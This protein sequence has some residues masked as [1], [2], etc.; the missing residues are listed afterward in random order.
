MMGGEI[1]VESEFG[2]GTTFRVHLPV[3]VMQD[4][5]SQA[6]S[7]PGSTAIAASK[8]PDFKD[9]GVRPAFI[10]NRGC[11]LVIDDDPVAQHLVQSVLVK[12]GYRVLTAGGGE[13]G[14][15]QAREVRPDAITLDVAMPGIDGWNVLSALKAA[16][17]TANI[18]VIIVSMMENKNMGFALGASEYLTKPVN[19]DRLLAIVAKLIRPR[20]SHPIMVIDD[21]A[22]TRRMLEGM[23]AKEGW[24]VCTVEN[25]QTA[26]EQASK[27]LPGLVLLDLLMPEMDGFTFLQKFR[28]SARGRQ[29]P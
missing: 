18:P 13:D 9:T 10:P 2:K 4:Q 12:E 29:S 6:S 5:K 28:A 19:R 20:N 27:N 8:V 26:L 21:D 11:V 22:D 1:R 3:E 14:L 7:Q 24:K 25:G 23:L 15:R 16:P 17:E